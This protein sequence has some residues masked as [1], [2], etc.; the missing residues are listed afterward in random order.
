MKRTLSRRLKDLVKTLILRRYYGRRNKRA[1]NV[2]PMIIYMA[3][4]KIHHGG[5]S[6]RIC[7]FISAYLY[8]KERGIAFKG[9]FVSPYKLTDYLCPAEYDWVIGKEELSFNSRDSKP[10]YLPFS[11]YPEE[12]RIARLLNVARYKQIH[13]YTNMRYSKEQFHTA[14]KE[15]F[16]Y[17]PKL[18]EKL[19]YYQEMYRGGVISLTFRFQQLLND[20]SEGK[21]PKLETEEERGKL[22]GRCLKCVRTLHSQT[23]KDILVTSDSGTFLSRVS[24]ESYVHTISGRIVHMDFLKGTESI[25]YETHL[26]SFVDLFMLGYAEKIYLADFA[27]LYSSSF[28][29]TAAL[30]FNKPFESIH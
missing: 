17:T 21:F 5:L 2:V 15:L 11:P 6:D 7:G 23:G 25:D 29:R 4:G 18:E 8:C 10:V 24:E 19:A 1:S 20:F 30:L 3:D 26:K 13:L 22:I 28:P 16:R 12:K 9:Y 14:F 27:P